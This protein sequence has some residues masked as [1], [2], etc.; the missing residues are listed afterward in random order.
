MSLLKTATSIRSAVH[1]SPI[2]PRQPPRGT[3]DE[4]HNRDDNN[5]GSS[6]SS[7]SSSGSD[8]SSDVE[9]NA[10]GTASERVPSSPPIKSIRKPSVPVTSNT[11]KRMVTNDKKVLQRG[12]DNCTE[13]SNPKNPLCGEGKSILLIEPG[14]LMGV[15]EH[16]CTHVRCYICSSFLLFFHHRCILERSLRQ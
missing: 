10:Y 13:E 7:S 16:A 11:R 6:S 3:Q 15:S 8:V 5:D 1:T 9:D 12:K 14:R 4:G 2:A